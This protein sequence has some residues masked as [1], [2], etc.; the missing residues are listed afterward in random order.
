MVCEK[1]GC[2]WKKKKMTYNYTRRQT[3]IYGHRNGLYPGLWQVLFEEEILSWVLNSHGGLGGGGGGF[4]RLADSHLQTGGA[5]ELNER[6]PKDFKLRFG[7]IR[8]NIAIRQCSLSYRHASCNKEGPT[9]SSESRL[10]THKLFSWILTSRQQH[11]TTFSSDQFN[12][13][14]RRQRP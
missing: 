4:P 7:L 5:L 13:A 8:V 9:L 2:G 14:L 3:H 10:F 11:R 12:F 1:K 6:S